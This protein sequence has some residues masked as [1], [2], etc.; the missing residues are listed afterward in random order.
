MERVGFSPPTGLEAAGAEALG[1]LVVD[2][3]ADQAAD[4]APGWVFVSREMAR[5]RPPR[6]FRETCGVPKRGL[7]ILLLRP[8][9]RRFACARR[10][11]SVPVRICGD[12]HL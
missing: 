2:Q 5:A 1:S 12:S 3:A 6:R 9:L 8:A 10:L 7:Q 11:V 4:Q